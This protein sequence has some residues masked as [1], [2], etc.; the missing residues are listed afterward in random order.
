MIQW[1][2]HLQSPVMR[3]PRESNMQISL[4]HIMLPFHETYKTQPA[5]LCGLL[6]VCVC[7]CTK[8]ISV[9]AMINELPF[10]FKVYHK[11]KIILLCSSY[12]HCRHCHESN[13]YNHRTIQDIFRKF[14][15]WH[16]QRTQNDV[17]NIGNCANYICD[18][19]GALKRKANHSKVSTVKWTINVIQ[20][21]L[22]SREIPAK[23]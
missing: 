23:N 18:D 1:T 10:I 8:F 15:L 19:I 13:T 16:Q 3:L 11:N 6:D 2:L 4:S 14:S 20:M 12:C 21:S 17:I 5:C 7:V 22:N 9:T